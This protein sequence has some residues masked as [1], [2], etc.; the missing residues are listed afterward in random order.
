MAGLQERYDQGIAALGPD[1][2]EIAAAGQ[3]AR[4]D[5]APAFRSLLYEHTCEAMYGPPEYGGNRD[6]VGWRSIGFAGD[7]QPRGWTAAEVSE[8]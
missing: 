4:L 8:P 7:V 3:D 2:A 6:V 5:A 1:F